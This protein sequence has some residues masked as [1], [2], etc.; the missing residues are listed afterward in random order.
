MSSSASRGGG[1]RTVHQDY[2][3]RVR[4]SNVLPPPPN[5]PKLLE[6]PNTGL[7]S[8]FY[9]SPA[10]ASRLAR[11]QPLNIEADAELGMPLD[12]IGMPGVF[13]GDESSIQSDPHPPPVHPHDRALLKPLSSLGKPRTTESGVSFLRRTEYISS[14]ASK[15]GVA[16]GSPFRAGINKVRRPEKRSSPEPDAGT[17]A[18]VKRK[19]DQSFQAAQTAARDRYSRVRHPT[20]KNL[21]LAAAYPLLPDLG[22]F[23]D[24]GAYV[25]VKFSNHP[26]AAGTGVY[27]SRLLSGIFKAVE[28]ADDERAALEA[29]TKAYERDPRRNPRP[30]HHVQYEFY[31][32][33]K[34]GV[35]EEFRRAFGAPEGQAQAASEERFSFNRVRAYESIED[36]EYTHATKYAEEVLLA[37][38]E[39]A[40][41]AAPDLG[42]RVAGGPR[43]ALYYP[44]MQRTVVRSQR[45]KQIARGGGG[46]GSS[47]IND[48][49][50]DNDGADRPADRLMISVQDAPDEIKEHIALIRADPLH[51]EEAQMDAE[52]DADE[53]V[54]APARKSNGQHGDGLEDENDD[55]EDDERNGRRGSSSPNPGRGNSNGRHRSDGEDEDEDD[56]L[57]DEDE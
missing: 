54:P 5:P 14:I 40:I 37:F 56:A 45:Q 39:D 19:I 48:D 43:A 7:S 22:A 34:T 42:S 4:Y 13:D 9:T 8:G 31:L 17:P 21:R 18:Y 26:V 23:P 53:D 44:V 16:G 30:Q 55:D 57:A 10:F 1:E 24:S 11:E 20:K 36:K 12:L 46:M 27:D 6:I 38:S 32:P 33:E 2:I 47:N 29:A 41:A 49:D 3:A 28:M 35:G 25:T 52:G 50:D 15:G 51:F